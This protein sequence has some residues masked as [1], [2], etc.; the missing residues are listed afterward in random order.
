MLFTPLTI[1]GTILRNRIVMPA[2]NTNFGEKDGSV[3][4]R[5]IDYF[6]ERGKGGT[7]LIISSPAYIDPSARKR[8]RSLLLHE[9]SY[10]PKLLRFTQS[11]HQTGAR[12]LLQL[13]HNGR[14]IKSSKDYKT[15]VTSGAV[16]PSAIPHLLTGDIPHALTIEE[17]KM[18]IEKFGDAARRA[19]EAGFDGVEIH[20]SHGYLIDEFFSVYSNRRI[21]E[22]GGSI[23]NRMRFPLEIVH[24]V[25]E[26]TGNDF[27]LCYRFN[28]SDYAPVETPLSDVI[29]LCQRLEKAGIDLL[30]L[31]AGN[32]E[33]PAML[34]RTLPPCSA[35]RGCYADLSAA[36]KEKVGVP[37]IVVGRINTPEIAENILIDGKADLVATGRAL[38]ADPYWPEKAL[39]GQSQTIRRCLGCSQGCQ[40][41]LVQ[42]KEITC[43]YNPEVGREN[44]R[45]QPAPKKKKVWVV[46]GGPGGMEAAVVAHL[47]GH[48]VEL[49]ERDNELGGQ[50]LLAAT[51]P[52]K[53][54]FIAV[55]DFLASEIKRLQIDVH[56]N[57]EITLEKVVEGRPDAMI[58]ATGAS[59]LIPDLPGI[60]GSNVMTAW[61]VLKGKTVAE[62]IVVVGGGLVG[63]ETGLF[64]AQKGRKVIIIEMLDKIALDAGLLNRARLEE[65]LKKTD[66]EARCNTEL[67]G[68]DEKGAIVR[69]RGMKSL[70]PA[71]TV[72][73][74]LGASPLNHLFDTLKDNVPEIYAVGDCVKPRKILEAVRE[75]YD[76]A[77]MI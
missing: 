34:L 41:Q 13:N 38:I 22:Y 55:R 71:D 35:P 51:P 63:I 48:Y 66:I 19:K 39:K 65:E 7:G 75:A 64:L 31:S 69:S 44:E 43:I 52:G 17:I 5:L 33:T 77:K 1:K 4:E 30:H 20:G 6:V 21:D 26:L 11:V 45:I 25:R 36:V 46:G 14:L 47:R 49:Y 23:E 67:V 56:L 74:A 73:L 27:L 53:E 3:S 24:R 70:L 28:A 37:L 60:R 2:M 50:S 58:I 16:G 15:A 9:D 57:E 18:L 42:E 32:S 29:Q 76:V 54:E 62:K 72:V 61:D 68:I 8:A 12:I 10:I 40:E 59:P